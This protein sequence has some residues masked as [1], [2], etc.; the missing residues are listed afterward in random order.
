MRK[1]RDDGRGATRG[2]I[3]ALAVLLAGWGHTVNAAELT[4]FRVGISEPA[5]TVP[6]LWMAQADGFYSGDAT[7]RQR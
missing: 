7:L 2:F 6:A 3:V 4:P 5:N 1:G